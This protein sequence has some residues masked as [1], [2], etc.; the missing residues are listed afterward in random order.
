MKTIFEASSSKHIEKER[1]KAKKLRSTKW[2]QNKLNNG[3]CYFCEKKI[4]KKLL[5]MDHLVPLA[6]GGFSIKNNLVPSCKTCNSEKGRTNI[7]DK[8]LTQESS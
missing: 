8:R 4:P 1:E 2:W 7:V 6:M 3:I 5:T